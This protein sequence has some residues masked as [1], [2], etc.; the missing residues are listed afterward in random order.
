LA[1]VTISRQYGSAGTEIASGVARELGYHLVDREMLRRLFEQYGLAEFEK[2]YDGGSGALEKLRSKLQDR[3]DDVV[4]VH[5]RIITEF[6]HHGDAVIV[7]RGAYAVLRGDPYVLNVRVQAP[8]NVRA[9]RALSR[10]EAGSLP[11]A[12]ALVTDRD[13]RRIGFIED[14]FG[15][16]FDAAS[17]FDLVLDTGKLSIELATS[18]VVEAARAV[19]RREGD[20]RV[21]A[22]ANIDPVMASAIADALKCQTPH[23]AGAPDRSPSVAPPEAFQG[24]H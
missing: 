18:L 23:R 4:Q 20:A 16:R 6:A 22:D 10:G 3:R 24:L 19:A 9:Q 14:T 12:E 11:E 15:I 2:V 1:V 8:A 17:G 21:P 5:G 7:G 13:Q